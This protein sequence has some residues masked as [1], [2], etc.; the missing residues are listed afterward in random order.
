MKIVYYGSI[1]FHQKYGGISRYYYNLANNLI[2]NDIDFKIIS[3]LYKNNHLKKLDKNY[4]KG[5]Y[6]K[7]YPDLRIIKKLFTISNKLYIDK[8]KP[9]I[10]HDTYYSEQIDNFNTLKVITVYDLIHEK[11]PSFYG[12]S[13]NKKKFLQYYDLIICISETTKKDL[14]EFYGISEKKIKVIYLS[15]DHILSVKPIKDY[16]KLRNKP[17]LLYVG[18]REKYKD[19]PTL[20]KAFGGSK[21]LKKDFDLVC[22]GGG[23]FSAR[24]NSYFSE[25]N[26]I[27]NIIQIDGGDEILKYLYTNCRL[28]V[29]T[30]IYEGFGIPILEAMNCNCPTLLSDCETHKE[31][32]KNNAIYFGK[33]NVDD[34]KDV[35]ENSLYDDNYLSTLSK[36]GKN[37]SKTFSWKKCAE[38]TIISYKEL[39]SK[40]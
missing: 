35:L 22:F 10:L 1:F 37:Y 6:F 15:G 34:L 38:Q 32:A 36:S 29:A 17:F 28:F 12:Q 16:P 4:K 13:N 39:N 7:R 9:D 25:L 24:E 8:I 19:F 26:I 30:S 18:S 21:K 20:L 5:I 27:D 33:E 14:I 11:F 31:V 23:K 40:F 3:S 2:E